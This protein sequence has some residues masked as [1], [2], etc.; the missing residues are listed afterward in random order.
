M[1]TIQQKPGEKL[2]DPSTSSPSVGSKVE[3]RVTSPR[4]SRLQEKKDQLTSLN[5]R[6]AAYI[7]HIRSLE[8]ENQKLHLQVQTFEE[9]TQREVSSIK[10]SCTNGSWR[11]LEN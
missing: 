4:V 8:T 3:A 5:D 9:T 11:Q 1:A 2:K 6:L 10:G 7:D